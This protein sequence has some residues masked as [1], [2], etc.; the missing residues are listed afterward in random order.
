MTSLQF[1]DFLEAKLA[2][3]GVSKVISSA[4][5]LADV[6]RLFER[7]ERARRVVEEALAA[8]AK[9]EIAAPAD[10]EERVRAYLSE[11]PEA[12]WD[13]A[14]AALVEDAPS[15]GKDPAS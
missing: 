12:S 10:L 2:E 14:V 3:H 6:Y 8:M 11:H 9:E 5:H 7:G 1:L 15:V 13:E 4:R